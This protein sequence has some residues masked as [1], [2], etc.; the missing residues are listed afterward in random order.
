MCRRGRADHQLE[1]PL[2]AWSTRNAERDLQEA[3]TYC[4]GRGKYH[5]RC[6]WQSRLDRLAR[7]SRA[8]LQCL[9]VTA[10]DLTGR[11]LSYANLAGVVG[12][13]GLAGPGLEITSLGAAGPPLICSGT[14][15]AAPFVTG[16]VALLWSRFPKAAVEQIKF[17]I[18]RSPRRGRAALV[19]PLL[20]AEEAYNTLVTGRF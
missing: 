15:V 18:T 10:C 11:P 9:P 6:S 14:S 7:R 4:A 5:R 16:A 2:R 3:L 13:R 8:I 19:P 1:R 20:N 17:A 12:R